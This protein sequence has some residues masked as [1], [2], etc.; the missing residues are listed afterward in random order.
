MLKS[1]DQYAGR[2][3]SI[4]GSSEFTRSYG[5]KVKIV[6]ATEKL[7]ITIMTVTEVSYAHELNCIL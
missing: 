4:R 7:K 3:I 5:W 6:Q 2:C 1:L